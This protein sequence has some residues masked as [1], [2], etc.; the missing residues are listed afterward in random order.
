MGTC[1]K[2]SLSRSVPS[3]FHSVLTPGC[4][5]GHSDTCFLPD[6]RQKVSICGDLDA[7]WNGE[8]TGTQELC[9]WI[10]CLLGYFYPKWGAERKPY[11]RMKHSLAFP[12]PLQALAR[13]AEHLTYDRAYLTS[14]LWVS[15]QILC[16]VLQAWL[17]KR[18]YLKAKMSFVTSSE[19][20]WIF[21]AVFST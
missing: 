9:F 11:I 15:V 10:A 7:E 13:G 3:P 16:F 12:C 21:M 4:C 8:G 19:K 2:L 20:P 1:L 6:F 17:L 18:R 5:H 14:S